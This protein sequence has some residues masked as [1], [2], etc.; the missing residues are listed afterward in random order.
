MVLTAWGNW[1]GAGVGYRRCTRKIGLLTEVNLEECLQENY[2]GRIGYVLY[3]PR[4]HPKDCFLYTRV[5][6]DSPQNIIG[7][8]SAMLPASLNQMLLFPELLQSFKTVHEIIL[9][10]YIAL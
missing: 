5:L 2:M 9:I 10:M 8:E 3:K 6:H 1:Y 7:C 4:L